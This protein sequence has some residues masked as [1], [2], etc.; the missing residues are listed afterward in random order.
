MKKALVKVLVLSHRRNIPVRYNDGGDQHQ[1]EDVWLL[2][3]QN[4]EDPYDHVISG[5]KDRFD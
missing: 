4:D 3:R 5:I 2:Y 1:H